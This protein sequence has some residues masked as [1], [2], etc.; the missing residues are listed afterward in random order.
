M[1]MYA[2]IE[3]LVDQGHFKSKEAGYAYVR[4][5]LE[6]HSKGDCKVRSYIT[7]P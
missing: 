3:K 1:L 4:N 5:L 6:L 2:R 7:L